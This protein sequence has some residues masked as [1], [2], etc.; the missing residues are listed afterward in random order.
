MDNFFWKQFII[1]YKSHFNSFLLDGTTES[2][3]LKSQLKDLLKK[4]FIQHSIFP[5]GA[6]V[7]FVKK[8][9]GSLRMCI[10]YWKLN[11]VTINIKYHLPRIDNLFDLLQG[12]ET[13]PKFT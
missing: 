6:L 11:I 9:D 1:E 13:F 3:E 5:W 12:Q 8:K 7:L 4:G 10:N 2:K